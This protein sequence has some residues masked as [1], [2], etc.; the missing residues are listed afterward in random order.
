MLQ[1][2][3]VR[4]GGCKAAWTRQLV[5]VRCDKVSFRH[6]Q[7]N[8]SPDPHCRSS[9]GIKASKEPLIQLRTLV[10]LGQLVANENERNRPARCSLL[11]HM[12]TGRRMEVL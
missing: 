5:T 11:S 3:I 9:R 2:Q 1:S 6:S 7:Y 12:D 10:Y 4:R 8:G